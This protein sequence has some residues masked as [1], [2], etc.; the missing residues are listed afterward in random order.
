MTPDPALV[1]QDDSV[2][3]IILAP[4]EDIYLRQKDIRELQKAKGAIRASIDVI[5]DQLELVPE[6]LPSG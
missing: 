3:R 6:E 5:M 4:E 1:Q 2:H